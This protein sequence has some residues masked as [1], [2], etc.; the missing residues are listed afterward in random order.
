MSSL[1]QSKPIIYEAECS[2]ENVSFPAVGTYSRGTLLVRSGEDM[3][4]ST[5]STDDHSGILPVDVVVESPG[6]RSVK[7]MVAG[8]A[9][10][11]DVILHDGVFTPTASIRDG[12]RKWGIFLKKNEKA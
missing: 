9:W 2:T 11:D 5:I 7:V 10:L 3:A 8:T 12:L 6:T 4:P 1:N